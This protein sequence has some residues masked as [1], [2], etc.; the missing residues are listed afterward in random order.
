MVIYNCFNAKITHITKCRLC[1]YIYTVEYRQSAPHRLSAPPPPLFFH[2][3]R[4]GIVNAPPLVYPPPPPPPPFS[5]RP[6][7]RYLASDRVLLPVI[8]H[9]TLPPCIMKFQ[10]VRD[11][12]LGTWPTIYSLGLHAR[13][14]RHD[15]RSRPVGVAVIVRQWSGPNIFV[16]MMSPHNYNA[17]CRL[18]LLSMA[19]VRTP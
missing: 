9:P 6:L 17:T 19:A 10:N 11:I 7:S 14:S 3:E 13:C 5:E 8:S 12:S 4:I 2:I 15:R 18:Q 1:R 16:N